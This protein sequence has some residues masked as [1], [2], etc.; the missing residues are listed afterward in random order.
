MGC[1]IIYVVHSG[2]LVVVCMKGSSHPG[3]VVVF[4]NIEIS[5]P[6][7]AS[8]KYLAGPIEPANDSRIICWPYWTSQIFIAGKIGPAIITS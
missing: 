3:H 2:G 8:N 4:A 1:I 6:Y 7:R 5:M